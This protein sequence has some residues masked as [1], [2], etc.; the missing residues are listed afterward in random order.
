MEIT[1]GDPLLSRSQNEKIPLLRIVF[2]VCT[3]LMKAGLST[4][5]VNKKI[6]HSMRDFPIHSWSR[7]D[8][9]PRPIGEAVRFLHAYLQVG[10]RPGSGMQP[11]KQGLSSKVF[12]ADTKRICAYPE[13]S[14][15]PDPLLTG[16]AVGKCSRP[17]FWQD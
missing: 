5:C 16:G 8:S 17:A 10:F 11:P 9:N 2:F 14:A 4:S 12:V 13:S 3:Q 15:L 1:F 6:P 7:R